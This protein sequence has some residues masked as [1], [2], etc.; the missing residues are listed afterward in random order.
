MLKVEAQ[1]EYDFLTDTIK[2]HKNLLP[3]IIIES[4]YPTY[5]PEKLNSILLVQTQYR[6]VK[7]YITGLNTIQYNTEGLNSK[8]LV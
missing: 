6:R 3:E 2:K 8:I 4:T 1:Y 7:H 5:N